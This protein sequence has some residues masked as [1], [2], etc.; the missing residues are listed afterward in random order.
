MSVQIILPFQRFKHTYTS[1][2]ILWFVKHLLKDIKDE[3]D[4]D[5]NWIDMLFGFEMSTKVMIMSYEIMIKV[6]GYKN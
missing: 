6:F 1:Y 4:V 5:S 3:V 2:F